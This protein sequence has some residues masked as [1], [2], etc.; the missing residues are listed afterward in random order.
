[1]S[2]FEGI[3]SAVV[4]CAAYVSSRVL[5]R[6][7]NIDKDKARRITEIIF[8]VIV[9]AFFVLLAIMGVGT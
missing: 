1:M 7:I 4:E 5:G 9:A 8:L 2:I 3:V 6:A